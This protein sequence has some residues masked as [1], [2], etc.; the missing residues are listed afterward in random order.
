MLIRRSITGYKHID[1]GNIKLAFTQVCEPE[2]FRDVFFS[3]NA[4]YY[5]STGSAV[6]RSPHGEVRLAEGEVALIAQYAKLDIQKSKAADG[7]DFRSVIFYLFPDHV[8]AFLKK[9]AQGAAPEEEG[10]PVIP[11]GLNAPLG[12]LMRSLLP[13]F[14]A[15]RPDRTT[16]QGL[17]DDALELLS[18]S[19]PA[20]MA[21]LAAHNRPMKIDL[22]EFMIHVTLYNHSIEELAQLTGRS[23][24]A[25]KREFAAI[26]GTTPHRWLLQQRI[27]H[28]EKILKQQELKPSEIY[29]LLGFKELSHFSAAFKKQKG[30][31]PTQ[32]AH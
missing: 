28:A 31:A 9:H 7:S 20:F 6:L 23:L 32:L 27:D 17:T 26:F 13:L 16:M 22:Y 29:H 21:F 4:V 24:S 30:I 14:N 12:E 11:L 25:F 2:L 18:R 19:H 8:D 1:L 15:P 5:V 3:A 10:P